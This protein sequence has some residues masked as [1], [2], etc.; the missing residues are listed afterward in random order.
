MEFE[1]TLRFGFPSPSVNA[2]CEGSP[3]G[4]THVPMMTVRI[5]RKV[6]PATNEDSKRNR[7][8][9]PL[10][11]VVSILEHTVWVCNIPDTMRYGQSSKGRRKDTQFTSLATSNAL[12]LVEPTNLDMALDP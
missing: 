1:P 3:A 11:T 2:S 12:P 10:Y 9:R 6:N 4:R 8:A 5:V 7:M